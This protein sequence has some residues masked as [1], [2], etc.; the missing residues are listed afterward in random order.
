MR[1]Y[2]A[3][4]GRCGIG[5]SQSQA[6]RSG[7]YADSGCDVRLCGHSAGKAQGMSDTRRD[8][9]GWWITAAAVIT[10]GLSTGLPYYNIAFFYDYFQRAYGWSRPDITLGFP[11]AALLTIWAG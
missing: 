5:Y 1:Q 4:R 9:Y 8:F 6:D 7:G 2:A 3:A 11:I 10:F